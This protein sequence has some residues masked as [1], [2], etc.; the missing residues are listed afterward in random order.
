MRELRLA[1]KLKQEEISRQIGIARTTYAM[2]EQNNR[3]P[4]H[5][6]LIKL[7]EFFGVTVD[8]LIGRSSD[9]G[10]VQGKLVKD[11]NGTYGTA[12]LFP[13]VP[14]G[15][16]EEEYARRAAAASEIF[17]LPAEKIAYIEAILTAIR[18]EMENERGK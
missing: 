14:E 18:K 13:P 9:Y 8:R 1:R 12:L 3:Q 16:S 6:T 5:E 2:Y 11:S 15:M 4:D 17:A 10:S 7:A